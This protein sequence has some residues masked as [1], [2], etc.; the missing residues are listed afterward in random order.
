MA[1]PASTQKNRTKDA[2]DEEVDKMFAEAAA[3]DVTEDARFGDATGD[4]PPAMLRGRAIAADVSR[5]PR[6]FSTRN[7]QPSARRMR[8]TSPNGEADEERRGKKLRGREPR[9]SEEKDGAT[10][11]KAST[12]DPPPR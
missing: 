5:L 1:A 3:E 9:A 11:K 4:E 12:T 10:L 6:S 7:W 8:P 2:I